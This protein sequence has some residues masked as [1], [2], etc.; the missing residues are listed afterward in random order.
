MN[1]PAL[2]AQLRAN[3][4]AA[5]AALEAG[6]DLLRSDLKRADYIRLLHAFKGYLAPWLDRI[7]ARL[8]DDINTMLDGRRHLLRLD[9][10]LQRLNGGVPTAHCTELPAIDDFA[11]ALGSSYVIE[12][13]MLGARVVGPELQRRFGLTA[14]SGC[15]YFSGDGDGTGKRWSQFRGLLDTR[16][17]AEEQA[18]AV[19]A[20]NRTFETLLNWFRLREVAR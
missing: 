12:G 16:L 1:S 17:S 9:A 5:H 8:P 7:S 15:A 10:D 3:T 14:D 20:A 13:S 18:A 2:S 19:A 4:A 11:S 6:L